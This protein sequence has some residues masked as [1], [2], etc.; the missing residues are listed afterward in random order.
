MILDLGLFIIY[1]PLFFVASIGFFILS[2]H[3]SSP[4]IDAV[5][6]WTWLAFGFYSCFAAVIVSVSWTDYHAWR[7]HGCSRKTLRFAK[8]YK[9]LNDAKMYDKWIASQKPNQILRTAKIY[10]EAKEAGLLK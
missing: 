3:V 1:L 8:E 9:K 7:E 4:N 2:W 10:K 6:V 5:I